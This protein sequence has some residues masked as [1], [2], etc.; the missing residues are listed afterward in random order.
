MAQELEDH[1]RTSQTGGA[2]SNNTTN[3]SKSTVV[4]LLT[5]Q[6]A[7]DSNATKAAMEAPTSARSKTNVAGV[8]SSTPRVKALQSNMAQT[9]AAAQR[10][11]QAQQ[12]TRDAPRASENLS[13]KSST[14]EFERPAAQQV[15]STTEG[16]SFAT[17]SSVDPQGTLH[18]DHFTGAQDTLPAHQ[19]QFAAASP[20]DPQGTRDVDHSTMGSSETSPAQLK[21]PAADNLPVTPDVDHYSDRMVTKPPV[22]TL[23]DA[24]IQYLR[25]SESYRIERSHLI[26]Y[27][28]NT[29]LSR[30]SDGRELMAIRDV[31]RNR[32]RVTPAG[33]KREQ[34]EQVANEIDD[35]LA[36]LPR[37]QDF[38][39]QVPE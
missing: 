30:A 15:R 25:R 21:L 27:T 24:T 11:H 8:S 18:V 38:Y 6:H 32:A 3:C 35:I 9:F 16:P 17:A 5:Q 29:H 20:V 7:G 33:T 34:Y 36:R 12:T 28:S 1:H 22:I 14:P 4:D 31:L 39:P 2:G 26:H 19:T 10:F 37:W 23:S 13:N